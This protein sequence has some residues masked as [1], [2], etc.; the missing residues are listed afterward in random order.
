M[1]KEAGDKARRIIERMTE[2]PEIGKI[3]EGTVKRIMDFGAFVEF[4]P[5][6]EGLVHIS[7]LDTSRVERVTDIV[8]EGDKFEVKLMK[9]DSEGRYNLSRKAVITG[10]E[11]GPDDGEERERRRDRRGGDRRRSRR[12]D[13]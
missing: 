10:E 2:E 8:K 1:T 4:L 12:P 9:K 13:R 6:T 7:Q 3:Y 11:P 5:G